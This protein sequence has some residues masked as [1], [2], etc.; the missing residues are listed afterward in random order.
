LFLALVAVTRFLVLAI[1]SMSIDEIAN[2]Q[3]NG[4]GGKGIVANH[5]FFLTSRSWTKIW[6]NSFVLQSIGWPPWWPHQ[7][8]GPKLESQS[9]TGIT[10]TSTPSQAPLGKCWYCDCSICSSASC[11][12]SAKASHVT[13]LMPPSNVDLSGVASTT[14][15]LRQIWSVVGLS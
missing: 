1:W 10:T 14:W 8:C 13:S 15:R 12:S 9:P 7:D 4:S 3:K 2:T 11:H 5:R 6:H